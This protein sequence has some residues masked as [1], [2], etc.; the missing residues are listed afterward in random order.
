MPR[1]PDMPVCV[2]VPARPGAL[3]V[4][5]TMVLGAGADIDLSVD[6]LDDVALAVHEAAVQLIGSGAT[7]LELGIK[8]DEAG[9]LVVLGGD[10]A[11]T[12]WPPTGWPDT[13]S[14]RVVSA[15]VD[16]VDHVTDS[17]GSAVSLT[18]LLPVA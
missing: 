17:E 11:V 3:R 2:S 7:R 14:G 8:P 5:R 12:P 18:R 13:L 6:A 1:F 9:L 4:L 15:L 10:V 16:G